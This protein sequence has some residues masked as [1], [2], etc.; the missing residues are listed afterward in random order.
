MT[1]S[2][3]LTLGNV[4]SIGCIMSK[5]SRKHIVAEKRAA[6]DKKLSGL[7]WQTLLWEKH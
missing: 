4:Q 3:T 1:T 5:P 6:L 7:R 2:S